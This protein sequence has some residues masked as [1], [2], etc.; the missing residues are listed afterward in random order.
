M[1]VQVVPMHVRAQRQKDCIERFIVDNGSR[2]RSFLFST[3]PNDACDLDITINVHTF[4]EDH[5]DFEYLHLDLALFQTLA[6]SG[7]LGG[8]ARVTLRCNAGVFPDSAIV[9]F[10]E[11][12]GQLRLS[13]LRITLIPHDFV[14]ASNNPHFPVRALAVFFQK[15]RRIVDFCVDGSLS[16]NREDYV[17]WAKALSHSSSLT[18]FTCAW[19]KFVFTKDGH[20][21]N[22]INVWDPALH[23]LIGQSGHKLSLLDVRDDPN[24][25]VV[26]KLSHGTSKMIAELSRRGCQAFVGSFR[27]CFSEMEDVVAYC[28]NTARILARSYSPNKTA[29]KIHFFAVLPGKEFLREIIGEDEL[30]SPLFSIELWESTKEYTYSVRGSGREHL[31][32]ELD[33]RI[34][35]PSRIVALLRAD[36]WS[37]FRVGMN[38]K[39]HVPRNNEKPLYLYRKFQSENLMNFDPSIASDEEWIR[40]KTVLGSVCDGIKAGRLSYDLDKLYEVLTAHPSKA[41]GFRMGPHEPVPAKNVTLDEDQIASILADNVALTSKLKSLKAV[42]ASLAVKVESA[43]E[44]NTILLEQNANLQAQLDSI[45][46]LD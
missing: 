19:N 33:S 35:E 23:A 30:Q 14:D 36:K 31:Y 9:K 28:R 21:S 7:N 39:L 8:L 5:R 6:D 40:M 38:V 37:P 2:F 42:N 18:F 25:S 12:L 32:V 11:T 20:H 13:K 26:R 44:H 46:D 24:E 16:G 34:L 1:D 27:L 15:A 22:E 41:A 17:L 10:M 3:P 4:A 45:G 43:I 29:V